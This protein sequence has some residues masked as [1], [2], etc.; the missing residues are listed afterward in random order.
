MYLFRTTP[1][2]GVTRT[3]CVLLAMSCLTVAQPLAA[4]TVE[5]KDNEVF[6][7]TSPGL[8]YNDVQETQAESVLHHLGENTP[9]PDDDRWFIS[10][11]I[12]N[13]PKGHKFETFRD[14]SLDYVEAVPVTIDFLPA[15]IQESDS[16]ISISWWA[17]SK[18]TSA[19]Q[20][21]LRAEGNLTNPGG[22]SG[23]GQR[24]ELHWAVAV[25]TPSID[26]DADIDRDGDVDDNDESNEESVGTV[27]IADKEGVYAD[28]DEPA[29]RREIV[30]SREGS[31]DDLLLERSSDKLKLY[32][33]ETGGAEQFG[34]NNEI[35]IAPGTYWLQGGT[36]PSTA[37]RAD[38]LRIRADN[39][40][41]YEDRIN[42]TVLWVEISAKASK[43]QT[44]SP[45]PIFDGYDAV[46]NPY[47]SN[48]TIFPAIVGTDSLGVQVNTTNNS[49]GHGCIEVQGSIKP[50]DL[51]FDQKITDGFL[52]VNAVASADFGF[53]F[54]RFSDYRA[55]RQAIT[56]AFLSSDNEPDDSVDG[57]QDTD[58]DRDGSELLIVDYDGPTLPAIS[59]FSYFTHIRAN[60]V[61]H[62]S[63]YFDDGGAERCS[64]KY[65][66]S[67][68]GD[69]ANDYN[70]K[71]VYIY[72]VENDGMGTNEV[73]HGAESHIDLGLNIANA[74]TI[75]G[76]DKK[77]VV[78]DQD[79]VVTVTGTHLSGIVL[80][81]K[82]TEVIPARTIAV[83]PAAQ[84]S[85]VSDLTELKATFNPA[86]FVPDIAASAG[87]ELIISNEK[88]HATV[89]GFEIID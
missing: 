13:P 33:A 73:R 51:S 58:P 38:Y 49:I 31:T 81:V 32:D 36:T 74:P 70:G 79:T 84:G 7:P 20:Y 55:Y 37:T 3:A 89:D 47:V 29:R 50:N 16:E 52:N 30:I 80:L 44:L 78:K 68:S 62:T 28:E 42:V 63:F 17:S 35:S 34:A 82:G 14:A 24:P 12:L 25:L 67:F 19:D 57:L 87:W 75:T 18:P 5:E 46:L 59:D 6:K 45:D 65:D 85:T 2:C 11:V 43:N 9:D 39:N 71:L 15:S 23:G 86:H 48:G 54:R 76:V 22:G 53:V 69:A 26:I 83:K 72:D 1:S 40:S 64:A 77:Q 66:W 60:F 21:Q 4:E 8:D 88:G 41:S 61:E 56:P 27:V 10:S